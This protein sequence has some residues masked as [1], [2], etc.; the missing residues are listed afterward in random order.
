MSD[1]EGGN[2]TLVFRDGK[3]VTA[4]PRHREIDDAL[5]REIEKQSGVKLR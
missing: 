5:V 3:Y 2:H 4:I 1:K